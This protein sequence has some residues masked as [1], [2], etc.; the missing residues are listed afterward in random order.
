VREP[1]V[2]GLAVQEPDGLAD[3]TL[4]SLTCGRVELRVHWTPGAKDREPRRVPITPRLATAIERYQGRH[5]R[6]TGASALPISER[7]SPDIQMPR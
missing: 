6:L 2:C 3:L 4:D 7:G 5:R 1:E